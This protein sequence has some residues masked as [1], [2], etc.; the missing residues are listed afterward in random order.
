MKQLLL[1]Q[2]ILI[3]IFCL[4]GISSYAQDF[5]LKINGT[6]KTENEI[7]DS[8]NYSANHPNL[9]SLFDEIKNTSKKLSKKGFLDNKIL[10]TKKLNDSSY[11]SIIALKNKIKEIHIYIGINNPFSDFQ[12]TKNDS[13]IIPYEEVENYLNQKMNDAEKAGYALTKINLENIRRKNLIIYAD[14]NFK[15]EKKRA[16]NSIILNYPNQDNKEIFPKGHLKQLNKKYIN[17]TFNQEIVK[18]LYNEIN[19]FQFIS[20]TKYPEIL[21]TQDSTKIYAYIQKRKANT[22]DGYIGFSNDENKK[23][24]LN[25]YVDITLQNIL[26]SG[27]EFSLYW[28]SDGNQ[29]KTFNTKLEIPYIF[30]S[31]LGIKAQLNI[32]KQDS[33]FQNTKTA[34]DL[35]YFIKY[36]SRIYVGYQSTESSDIQNTN[37]TTISDYKNSYI[38][39]SYDYRKLN[40]ANNLFP[41]KAFMNLVFGY[42]KRDTNNNPETAESSKQ[43]YTNINLSYNFE[44]NEKNFFNINSQNFYLNSKNYISNELFRFGGMSSIRGFLENSLQAN[45]NAL[46][47]TEYRYVASKNLYINSILDYGLYQDFTSNRN[48]NKIK[49]LIGIGVGTAIQTTN[50]LLKITLTNGAQNTS[51]LQLYNTI[52]NI[53]YNVKF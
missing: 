28:K 38:T 30:N 22:F 27:E 24:N 20:Q 17:R 53:C 15:S 48:K 44:L 47:L 26:H 43:F 23:L 10:E 39:T 8:L 11:I 3:Y 19:N 36:N 6:N 45:F 50:G 4:T 25:G 21:F 46:I 16:L 40:V 32:F 18:E 51:E 52:I 34:I 49:K 9:K 2:L 41:Q 29:Q 14:L 35:G 1:K 12:K 5:T 7:I 13:V 33:T 37:N 42:G 31:A